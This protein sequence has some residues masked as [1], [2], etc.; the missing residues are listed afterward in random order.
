M[1]SE[2][3]Q[4][5]PFATYNP[6]EFNVLYRSLPQIEFPTYFPTLNPRNFPERVILTSTT[7]AASLSSILSETDNETIEAYLIT[8]I[9]LA[10][11]SLLGHETEVWKANREL[12]GTLQGIKKGQEPDRSE[13]CIQKVEDTLGF[14]AGRF[15][16][17]EAFGGDSKKKGTKVI[18]GRVLLA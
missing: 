9:A 8:R 1:Y 15:F 7:Y 14:G 18:T 3:L 4:G 17:Q 2:V 12:V 11:A 5:N 10:Y 16:V 6:V 13:W